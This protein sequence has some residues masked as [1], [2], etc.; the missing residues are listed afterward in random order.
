LKTGPDAG[1]IDCHAYGRTDKFRSGKGIQTKRYC[2]ESAVYA[3]TTLM[4]G[5][6]QSEMLGALA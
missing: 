3:K 2:F 4:A 5:L 6:Q 1:L